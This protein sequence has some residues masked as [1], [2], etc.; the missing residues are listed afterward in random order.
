MRKLLLLSALALSLSFS[1]NAQLGTLSVGPYQSNPS[2]VLAGPYVVSA[3]PVQ[4]VYRND[5]YKAQDSLCFTVQAFGP[6]YAQGL[7]QLYGRQ[8]ALGPNGAQ[9]TYHLGELELPGPGNYLV[10]NAVYAY[11]RTAKRWRSGPVR[12]YVL[13]LSSPRPLPVELIGFSA[14]A[15]ADSVA[16]RWQTASESKNR[17]F[18]VERS[19]DG[20]TF[21]ARRFVASQGNGQGHRYQVQEPAPHQRAYYRLRQVDLDSTESFSPV[22][23]VAPL[24]LVV[25]AYPNPA[26]DFTTVRGAA[27]SMARIYDMSGHLSRQQQVDAEGRL[28]LRGLP[29]GNYLLVVGE[30][31][32]VSRTRL[33]IF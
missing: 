5:S 14:V 8:K 17:G 10:Q 18:W 26:R 28:D 21:S 32:S 15:G 33:V 22:A 2:G 3:V 1:A 19:S 23:S 29:T 6:G 27:G 4:Q 31:A 7:T 16:L 25:T 11:D 12:T 9:D 20:V 24:R 30:H 13:L